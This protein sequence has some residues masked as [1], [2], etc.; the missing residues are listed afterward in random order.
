V[1]RLAFCGGAAALYASTA[2]ASAPPVG[3]LPHGPTTSVRIEVG[4]TYT[5]RLPKPKVAGRVWRIARPVDASIVREIREGETK[6][7]VWVTFRAAGQGSA[8][9]V[10]A[11]T[12]G[13]RSHAY[14]ARTFAFVVGR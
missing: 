7:E 1:R 12:L 3:R 11:M 6:S 10:F 5:A 9:V 2:L 13:E 14:A 4:K 8:R